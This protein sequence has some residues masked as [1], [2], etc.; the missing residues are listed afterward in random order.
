[1]TTNTN[2]NID[3]AKAGNLH[4]EKHFSN[5]DKAVEKQVVNPEKS[6]WDKLF[7]SP[8]IATDDF[9]SE[10]ESLPQQEREDL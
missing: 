4:T 5:A 8:V 9:M 1:M 10:R 3:R 7:N 2:S 6:A